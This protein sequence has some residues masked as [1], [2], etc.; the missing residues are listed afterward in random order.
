[1]LQ[2]GIIDQSY[3]QF[4]TQTTPP[5]VK[6]GNQPYTETN[7]P[8]WPATGRNLPGN[9]TWTK[10]EPPRPPGN[11]SVTW[12]Q[13]VNQSF[14]LASNPTWTGPPNETW[15][16]TRL[17]PGLGN[18]THGH[19]GQPPG[20]GSGWANFNM[21]VGAKNA[22]HPVLLNGTSNVKLEY[23]TINSSSNGQTI[24]NIA[25]N[26]SIAQVEFDRNGSLQLIINSSIKP[27]QVYADSLELAETQNASG[28]T[29]YSEA[30]VYS[31]E[32]H[33]LVIFADPLSVTLVYMQN[34]T[35]MPEFQASLGRVLTVS[36][37][38]GTI[39]TK[40][41]KRRRHQSSNPKRN[42]P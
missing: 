25:F 7:P 40:R 23:V 38:G 35:P 2:T 16:H 22:T 17:P 21:S 41:L 1:M 33:T 3:G 13:M 12:S 9:Q 37:A 39:V 28:L 26:D 18:Q 15:T 42:I 4:Q 20:L 6:E 34:A 30:W 19:C 32:N 5:M 36:I 31:Q 24:R 11:Q 29:P 14:T 10:T 27:T 8:T